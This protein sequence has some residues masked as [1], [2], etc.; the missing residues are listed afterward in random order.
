MPGINGR[1]GIAFLVGIVPV[2]LI[3]LKREV[4]LTGLHLCFLQTKEISVHLSEDVAE[5]FALAG[6][7]T[8]DVP[9]DKFHGATVWVRTLPS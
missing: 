3:A 7:Q 6:P 2:G 9:T 8:V 4:E 1:A 5:A